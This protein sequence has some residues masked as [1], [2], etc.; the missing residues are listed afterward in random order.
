M[1]TF[2]CDFTHKLHHNSFIQTTHLYLCTV[3]ADQIDSHTRVS[4]R[5]KLIK[6]S[7]YSFPFVSNIVYWLQ[8]L[9]CLLTAVTSMFADCSYF[10]VC[11]LQLLPMNWINSAEST[12]FMKRNDVPVHVM[13]KHRG[14][15][16]AAPLIPNLDSGLMCDQFQQQTA[17]TP[18]NNAGTNWIGK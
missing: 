3:S 12:R 7:A 10:D 11:W 16:G 4:K 6:T 5:N 14:R 18:R 9:R 1:K 8:L 17:L 13:K 15:R 2:S